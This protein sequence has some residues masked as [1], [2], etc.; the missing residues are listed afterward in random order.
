MD[1]ELARFNMIEQQV[2]P[3]NVLDQRVLDSL[4]RVSRENFVPEEYRALAFADMNIPIGDGQVM[5]QP[6]VEARMI[7]ALDLKST[8]KVLEIG[9]GTGYT[10]ALLASLANDVESVE[11][12][13]PFALM[14]RNN[15][16]QS[17]FENVAVVIEDASKGW[18]SGFKLDCIFIS[19]SFIELPDA[20]PNSLPI[21]GRLVAVTGEDPLMSA[22]LITRTG[23]SSWTTNSLFETSL[24]ALDNIEQPERFIF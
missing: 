14:A 8:D 1:I 18:S 16:Q 19:G 11:I 23:E 21:G 3:W 10:T 12:R 6:K 22:I 20:Y 15:L 13:E 7:Q 17:G 5:M 4:N 2:R 9:T 24:P